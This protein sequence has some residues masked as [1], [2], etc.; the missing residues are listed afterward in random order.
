MQALCP[1]TDNM[2][3]EYKATGQHHDHKDKARHTSSHT[4]ARQGGQR[5]QVLREHPHRFANG[6]HLDGIAKGGL[7]QHICI[8]VYIYIYIYVCLCPCICCYICVHI[9]AC[10]HTYISIYIFHI[11]FCLSLS[12]S[13]SLCLY[14]SLSI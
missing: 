13:V 9:W 7:I 2:Q 3:S 11:L 4:R 12:L 10:I 8:Y 14:M 5:L 1:P 6:F